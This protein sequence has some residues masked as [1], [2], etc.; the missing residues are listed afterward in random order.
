MGLIHLLGL[1]GLASVDLRGCD[2]VTEV[3]LGVLKTMN[4]KM[5]LS[6]HEDSNP[7]ELF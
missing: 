1:K 3:G 4:L 2:L 6:H 5:I 7:I